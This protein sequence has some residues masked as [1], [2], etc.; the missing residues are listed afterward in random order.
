MIV[1]NYSYKGM[2]FQGIETGFI[3][4]IVFFIKNIF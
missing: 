2:K 4:R 3:E 1:K